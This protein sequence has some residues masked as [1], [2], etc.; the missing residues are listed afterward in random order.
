MLSPNPLHRPSISEILD[1]PWMRVSADSILLYYENIT[2]VP[3]MCMN[4]R[5][6]ISSHRLAQNKSFM[7]ICIMNAWN[8]PP[9]YL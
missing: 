7:A 1:H 6:K 5:R 4:K 8:F 9:S 2:I 3:S